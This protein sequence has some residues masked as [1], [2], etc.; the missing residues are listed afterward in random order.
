VKP[1]LDVTLTDFIYAIVVGAAFQKIDAPILSL[2][3]GYLLAAFFIII[4]DWVLY[5]IQAKK[6]SDEQNSNFAKSLTIDCCVL[7]AWYCAAVSGAHV[8]ESPYHFAQD[9]FV[10]LGAFHVLTLSWE[11]SFKGVTKNT[12]RMLPDIGSIAILVVAFATHEHPQFEFIALALTVAWLGV[13]FFAW[14]DIVFGINATPAP[15]LSSV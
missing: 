7:L 9:Y 11:L 1:A 4:D 15:N 14:K 5:H 3:N 6:V 12:G 10:A 8:K 2:Q 13:R